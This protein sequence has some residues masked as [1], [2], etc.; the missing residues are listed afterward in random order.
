MKSKQKKHT[1]ATTKKAKETKSQA[2]VE[3]LKQIEDAKLAVQTAKDEL[4]K[5]RKKLKEAKQS[6]KKDQ[7]SLK[8][9]KKSRL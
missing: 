7:K 2:A 8:T 3:I 1:T 5:A 9:L 4:K 6:A